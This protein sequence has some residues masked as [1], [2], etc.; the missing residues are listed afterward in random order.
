MDS[1]K[2]YILLLMR[3]AELQVDSDT[4]AELD[5]AREEIIE[6]KER[7]RKL[8]EAFAWME[9]NANHS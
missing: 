3:E 5:E 7:I 9:R 6:M 1:I 2:H 4:Y 8:E